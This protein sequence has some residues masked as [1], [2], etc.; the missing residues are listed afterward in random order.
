[1]N[2]LFFISMLS[3][4]LLLITEEL[5]VRGE[6]IWPCLFMFLVFLCYYLNIYWN[7][8]LFHF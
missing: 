7:K 3:V 2:A 8:N 6:V 1:L 4:S 5:W